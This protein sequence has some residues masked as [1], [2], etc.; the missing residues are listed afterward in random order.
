MKQ[1]I[2]ERTIENITRVRNLIQIYERIKDDKNKYNTDILRA[3]VV[4]L[5]A[6]LE[7][8]L[9]SIAYVKLPIA[10]PDELHK[11]QCKVPLGRIAEYRDKTVN[12]LI[13]D[14]MFEHL[15]RAT[16]NNSEDIS[17]ALKSLAITIKKSDLSQLDT[18]IQR[19]H[20]IVHRADRSDK[21]EELGQ[22]T[23]IQAL[24]LLKWVEDV[25]CFVENVF[26]ATEGTQ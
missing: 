6:A 17:R 25:E 9:R 20:R 23:S 26:D 8:C 1:K 5:H 24:H 10:S 21:E 22:V 11:T 2:R 3:A 16:Y 19:R 4:L 15:E 14:V 13:K 7:D 18:A 12:E